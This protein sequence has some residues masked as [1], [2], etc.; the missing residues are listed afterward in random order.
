MRLASRGHSCLNA[1]LALRSADGHSKIGSGG[2]TESNSPTISLT[3]GLALSSANSADFLFRV[4][5]GWERLVS[6][7]MLKH[8]FVKLHAEKT[9]K[10]EQTMIIFII[11]VVLLLTID[12]A[13]VRWG[14][15]IRDGLN[16]ED[17]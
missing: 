5:L 11:F 3:G 15:D 16:S 7:Y 4:Y 14:F 2:L 17:E 9:R 10:K 6:R 13:A 1:C 12:L 8:S